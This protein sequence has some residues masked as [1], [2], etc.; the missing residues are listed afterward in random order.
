MWIFA[1]DYE[2]RGDTISHTTLETREDVCSCGG[3]RVGYLE[4]ISHELEIALTYRQSGMN[5]Q[6]SSALTL[7]PNPNDA[8]R[9]WYGHSLDYKPDEYNPEQCQ[10]VLTVTGQTPLQYREEIESQPKRNLL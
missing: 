7:M 2:M 4:Q 5:Y 3:E 10:M 8:V 6:W 9:H 1:G